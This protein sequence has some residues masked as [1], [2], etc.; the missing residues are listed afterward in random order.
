MKNVAIL[1]ATGYVGQRFV[2][3]LENHSWFKVAA[4]AASERSV[5]KSY[6]EACHWLLD[7]PMPEPLKNLTV[8]DCLPASVGDVDLVFSCL[9][10]GLAAD[11]EKAFAKA[12]KAVVSK[13]SAHRMEQDVP[14]IIPEVNPEHL[15]LIDVQ[16]QKRGWD[17][18]ISTDPNCSTAPLAISLKPLLDLGIRRVH[19]AT[20]QA[21]SGAGYPGVAS[22]DALANVVPFISGEEEKVETEG[23]KML[24][25]MENGTVTPACFS[26]SASCNRVPVMEGHMENVFV[27]FD[28]NVDL[29]DILS[30]WDRFE[31]EPQRQKLPS[32][33]KAISYRTE[34]NRPQHRLDVMAGNG[35]TTTV[36][37]LRKDGK[38]S[39]KFTLLSHNTIRGAAGNGILHAEL[40]KYKSLL[41]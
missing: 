40:L 28:S 11:A 35:M 22:L 34:A 15:A 21:L 38:N 27:E 10:G 9:P 31:G 20:L 4:V 33:Q 3:L 13:A 14:L 32:S 29:D 7:T 24:G 16:R 39:V 17:G 12:G 5:G 6:A 8:A 23:L 30:R 18:F 36:G 41:G 1:G 19:V 25:K 37:R 26:V 2:Q